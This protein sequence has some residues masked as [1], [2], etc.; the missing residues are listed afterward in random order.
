V[1]IGMLL[2][3]VRTS[4]HLTFSREQRVS[5]VSGEA[6]LFGEFLIS[7]F[8]NFRCDLPQI[9]YSCGRTI[10]FDPSSI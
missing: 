10:L 6:F 1:V 5:V 8:P 3:S 9:F 7:K 2:E 4:C